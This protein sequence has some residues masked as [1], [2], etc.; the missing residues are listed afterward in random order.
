M[1]TSWSNLHSSKFVQPPTPSSQYPPPTS[2][3]GKKSS[4]ARAKLAA[5][6]MVP[7]TPMREV[8]DPILSHSSK[9][10]GKNTNVEFDMSS[11]SPSLLGSRSSSLSG[12][13]RPRESD[14]SVST[15]QAS[16]R[17]KSV[18]DTRPRQGSSSSKDRD[19]EAFQ[20]GLIAVFVP[21]ALKDSARGE[22]GNYNDL[23]AHFLPT[24]T[25]PSPAL[26]TL[27]PLLR[28][29]SAHVSLLKSDVHGALVSAIIGL[30]WAHGDERFVKT[31]V[32]WAGVL[33]SAH[34]GWTKEVIQ[35]ATKGLAWRESPF[36]AY[37]PSHQQKLTRRTFNKDRYPNITKSLSR[38]TSSPHFPPP[39]PHPHTTQFVGPDSGQKVST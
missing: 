25:N 34:P 14:G 38:P 22:M 26:S 3:S 17:T 37:T 32:G 30:P 7:P 27:L 19:R 28:A 24:P 13:K 18:G 4:Q 21:K 29:I 23:L 20:S 5:M 33:V 15:P 9:K 6:S 1:A 16:R 39:I 11:S 36:P 12:R 8:P 31:F 10:N 35:M 2:T